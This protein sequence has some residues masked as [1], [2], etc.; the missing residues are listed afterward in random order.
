MQIAALALWMRAQR[1]WQDAGIAAAARPRITTIRVVCAEPMPGEESL[2]QEFLDKQ[3]SATP[4]DRV[5]GQLVRR[6][7]KP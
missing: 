2:L 4:E 3:L 6:V 1:A 5:L 7:F